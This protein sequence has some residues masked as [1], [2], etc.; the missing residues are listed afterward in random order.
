MIVNFIFLIHFLYH[1]QV[2]QISFFL[3]CR[4]LKL[5]HQSLS[6]NA[7]VCLWF[8]ASPVELLLLGRGGV[9]KGGNL[10][11]ARSSAWED[12]VDGNCGGYD[13]VSAA[14]FFWQPHRSEGPFFRSNKWT[15]RLVRPRSNNL[16]DDQPWPWSCQR[17]AALKAPASQ[18]D[19][20]S[21]LFLHREHRETDK[22]VH[23]V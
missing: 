7:V 20:H 19:G 8:S 5:R 21:L 22:C 10:G 6:Q 17:R 12:C 3:F 1:Y 9:C 18:R 4:S 23:L 13:V 14:L 15:S 2:W 11:L 16:V